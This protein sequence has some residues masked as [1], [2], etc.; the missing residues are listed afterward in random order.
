M[1][2]PVVV[3]TAAGYSNNTRRLN[4]GEMQMQW[5][6]LYAES[7]WIHYV[8][9]VWQAISRQGEF[10]LTHMK[11]ISVDVGEEVM[12]SYSDMSNHEC[13]ISIVDDTTLAV[14][15]KGFHYHVTLLDYEEF[16]YNQ[17]SLMDA[18]GC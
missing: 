12:L 8:Y 10:P 3:E 16:V 9:P 6:D 2:R 4:H 7:H 17:L 18:V 13:V 5:G 1:C 14:S 11:A 15:L